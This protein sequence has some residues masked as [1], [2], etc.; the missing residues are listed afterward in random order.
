M[1]EPILTNKQ[2]RKLQTNKQRW[3]NRKTNNKAKRRA[4][5]ESLEK[6]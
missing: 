1:E 6:K 2:R 5:R 4:L 3:A